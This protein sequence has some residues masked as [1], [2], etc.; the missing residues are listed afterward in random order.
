MSERTTQ[1]EKPVAKDSSWGLIANSLTDRAM[2]HLILNELRSINENVMSNHF[3]L[4]SKVGAMQGL[5]KYLT[6]DG[7]ANEESQEEE[8][9]ELIR[10][11]QKHL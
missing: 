5:Q 8:E 3:L 11:M 10:R 6:L 4:A 1:L 2:I 9:E 7:L